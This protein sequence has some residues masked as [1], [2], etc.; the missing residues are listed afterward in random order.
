LYSKLPK[1]SVHKDFALQAFAAV[2]V[3][4]TLGNVA[5]SFLP[6]EVF[7]YLSILISAIYQLGIGDSSRNARTKVEMVS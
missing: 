4:G 1:N 7:L 6:I 3:N 5:G 2:V